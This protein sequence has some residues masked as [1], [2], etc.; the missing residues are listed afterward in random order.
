MKIYLGHEDKPINHQAHNHGTQIRIT[1][2]IKI[3]HLSLPIALIKRISP[4]LQRMILD[5][6]LKIASL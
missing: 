2:Q 6:L 3:S 1:K 4:P 5:L